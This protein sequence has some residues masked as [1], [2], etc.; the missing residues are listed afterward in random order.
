M[1]AE[2][3]AFEEKYEMYS[4]LIFRIA[5]I[6]L[7][8]RAD[9]EDVV[10]DVF[11]KVLSNSK[12]FNEAEGEKAWII[13]V[14]MNRCKNI[15]K[16]F[17]KKKTDLLQSVIDIPVFSEEERSVIK[18]VAAL[19]EKYKTV[20]YLHYIEGYKVSEISHM[21]HASPS[22]V[23]MRLARARKLLKS[24]MEDETHE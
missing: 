24:V 18:E 9:A 20:I 23:K 14:T 16:S 7:K 4:G 15:L 8:N 11:V 6:F 10:H 1:C 3:I 13:K 21:L 2:K 5:L 22:A 12:N 19:S 17:W